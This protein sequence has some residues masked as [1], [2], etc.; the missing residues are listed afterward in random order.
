MIMYPL[1]GQPVDAVNKSR[2]TEMYEHWRAVTRMIGDK[3]HAPTIPFLEGM[4]QVAAA[5]PD[6]NPY[7]F[8]PAVFCNQDAA[9]MRAIA[10]YDHEIVTSGGV[11]GAL[12]VIVRIRLNAYAITGDTHVALMD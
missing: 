10:G 6:L 12:G 3:T 2:N 1:S 5:G 11:S 8:F 9:P 4:G 7:V